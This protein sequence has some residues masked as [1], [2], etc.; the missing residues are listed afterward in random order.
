[1]AKRVKKLT[2]I[3]KKKSGRDASG[4]ISV[5]HRGG[6]HKRFI[7][8]IDWKRDKHELSGRVEKIEYDPNRNAPIALI[9]YPDGERRY[10]LAP[11]GLEVGSEVISGKEAPVKPGNAMPLKKVPLGVEV[12]NLEINPGKGGQMVRGAGT[13]ALVKSKSDKMA[14][15]EL[16]SGEVRLFKLNC[17]VTIGQI[18][19]VD[20]NSRK[21][22][23]AG[24]RRRRGFRP[25]VRGLAQAPSSHPHG[26]G[27]V[28]NIGI[29]APKT[30][31][32]KRTMGKKTRKKNKYS[33]KVIVKRRK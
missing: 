30:P 33:D 11:A 23:K 26:G 2:K 17:W 15:V 18:G 32:G 7:R 24:D 3:K 22:K 25:S 20:Y 4:Q 31:W 29:K 21:L 19:N 10:I 6:E 16:P 9:V 28:H 5:R 8:K 1:M 14:K 13:S 12:H 27:H